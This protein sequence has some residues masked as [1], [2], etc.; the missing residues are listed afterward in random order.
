M[1]KRNY[2][3]KNKVTVPYLSVIFYPGL[4][5][6]AQPKSISF[7]F[8]VLSTKSIL[9]NFKSLCEIL[10]LWQYSI[11]YSIYLITIAASCSVNILAYL[12]KDETE[13]PSRISVIM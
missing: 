6:A 11:P 10:F 13:P 5:A 7:R 9:S 12:K 1:A 4:K 3:K 2:Y 8:K